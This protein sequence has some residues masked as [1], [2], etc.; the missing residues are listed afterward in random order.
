[1]G[2][3]GCWSRIAR[4]AGRRG[5][6]RRA[7]TPWTS[8]TIP[9]HTQEERGDARAY[10]HERLDHHAGGGLADGAVRDR[11]KDAEDPA[12]RAMCCLWAAAWPRS[13][14]VHAPLTVQRLVLTAR[15][16]QGARARALELAGAMPT[17]PSRS[18]FERLSVYISKFEVVFLI[19]ALDRADPVHGRSELRGRTRRACTDVGRS[20]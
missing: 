13:L 5:S 4:P 14:P 1:M 19:E 16:R 17:H 20:A 8:S 15:L 18:G 12:A 6:T 7:R 11:E 2:G 3:F 10:E 9:S